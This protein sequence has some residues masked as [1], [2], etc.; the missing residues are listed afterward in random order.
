MARRT[1]S[2]QLFLGVDSE[3]PSGHFAVVSGGANRLAPA[4]TMPPPQV[5]AAVLESAR[6]LDAM[7]GP[8]VEKK[9]RKSPEPKS[10]GPRQ[11]ARAV[12]EAQEMMAS[13][14]W[15]G[16]EPRHLVA[17]YAILHE[18]VYS[19]PAETLGKE[20]TFAGYAARRTLMHDFHDD[21]AAMVEYVRW[22]FTNEQRTEKWRRTQGHASTFR[23]SWRLLFSTRGV[24]N[25][26]VAQARSK[27]VR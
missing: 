1:A 22:S 19:V 4:P 15:A 6:A 10:I 8:L 9:A 3:P 14:D 25:M 2:G 16:A 21:R 7:V 20:G 13:G 11:H 24:T 23:L 26:R 18:K 17:L 27:G 5:D 12:S